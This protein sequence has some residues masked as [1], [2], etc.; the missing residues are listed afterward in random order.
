MVLIERLRVYMC[1][2]RVEK[3][4]FF[5]YF[6]HF[7]SPVIPN[8]EHQICVPNTFKKRFTRARQIRSRIGN[9][10]YTR[11]QCVYLGSWF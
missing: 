7:F 2:T 11:L 5:K 8:S 3:L 4:F 9:V 10:V 1:Q 6:E